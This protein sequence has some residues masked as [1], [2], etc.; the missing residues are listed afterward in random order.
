MRYSS[1]ILA[2]PALSLAQQQVPL[3]DQL[4]GWF[5]KAT[6]VV[7][8]YVPTSV[9]STVP[10]A[11]N[12]GAAGVASTAVQPLN[13]ANYKQVL[14]PSAKAA[15]NAGPEE[16]LLYI[17][18]SN[19]TCYGLC[20]KADAAWNKAA[21]V[22]A[23]TSSPPKL[24]RLDCEVDGVL[25]NMWS[26]GPPAIYHFLLPET[27]A[28]QSKPATTARFIQ[29]N[30]TEI[31]ASDITELSTKEKYKE[32]TPYEG[33]FHPIDGLLATTG[34]NLPYGYVFWALN[35]MPSWLP[36]ILISFVSR[37]FM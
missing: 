8:G 26:A 7:Q 23:A 34:A 3:V 15:Q 10:E 37:R 14:S 25:C 17:T 22:L 18:G 35:K 11:V 31:T 20:D 27:L 30:R 36:M 6:E 12:A 28:D 9:P 5:N 19:K 29:L 33:L 1:V 13:L 16:V 32:T 4:K 24:A 2:L 21:A